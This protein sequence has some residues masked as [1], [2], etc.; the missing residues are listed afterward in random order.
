MKFKDNQLIWEAY[1]APTPSQPIDS[2]P[3]EDEEGAMML[4]LDPVG[5]V[6]LE[7]EPEQ[8]LGDVLGDEEEMDEVLYSDIKKLAD[9]SAKIL[10]HCKGAEIDTW[11]LAKLIKASE[12]VSDVWHRLD[13]KADFANDGIDQSDNISL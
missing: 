10:E 4:E 7:S 9:Y 2:N 1:V 13:A 12:Y 6:S 5:E 11:M 3:L 8:D